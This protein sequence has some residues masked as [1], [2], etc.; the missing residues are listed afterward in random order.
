MN[1]NIYKA[2][3]INFLES[4]TYFQITYVQL[5]LHSSM[6]TVYHRMTYFRGHKFLRILWNGLEP[7]NIYPQIVTLCTYFYCLLATCSSLKSFLEYSF[8]TL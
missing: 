3:A 2:N 6:L 5:S 4:C 1:C 7:K 8:L